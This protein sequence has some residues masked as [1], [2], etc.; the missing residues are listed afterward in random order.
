[1]RNSIQQFYQFGESVVGDATLTAEVM[2]I[3]RHEPVEQQAALRA[4]LEHFYHFMTKLSQL[5][6]QQWTATHLIT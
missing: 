6:V 5:L 1:V 4:M 3:G 2:V